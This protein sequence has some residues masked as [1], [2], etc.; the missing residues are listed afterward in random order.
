VWWCR[1]G[2]GRGGVVWGGGGVGG[3]EP[4]ALMEED[5]AFSVV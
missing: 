2:G 3:V 1:F 5:P 4:Y